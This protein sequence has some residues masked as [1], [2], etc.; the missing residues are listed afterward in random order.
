MIEI[1][2]PLDLYNHH[3]MRIRMTQY[4]IFCFPLSFTLLKRNS[5]MYE[6]I[7]N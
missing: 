3:L 1:I 4:Y 6:N 2:T 5:C 7:Y